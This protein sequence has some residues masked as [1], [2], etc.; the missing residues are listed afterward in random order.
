MIEYQLAQCEYRSRDIGTIT[1]AVEKNRD[2]HN[3]NE[4][5]W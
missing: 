1:E 5:G 4:D 2:Q 3:T